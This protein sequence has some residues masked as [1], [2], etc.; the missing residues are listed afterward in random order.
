MNQNSSQFV[1]DGVGRTAAAVLPAA[2]AM[3]RKVPEVPVADRTPTTTGHALD[4]PGMPGTVV[5]PPEG[6]GDFMLGSSRLY[7]SHRRRPGG[8]SVTLINTMAED[9]NLG[10]WAIANK[11]KQRYVLTGMIKAARR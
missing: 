6:R 3:D 8:E 2:A 11:M 4:G 5:P 1:G 10:G 9:V 7:Q